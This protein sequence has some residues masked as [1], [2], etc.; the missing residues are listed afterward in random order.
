MCKYATVSDMMPEQRLQF[1]IDNIA[2]NK[3]EQQAYMKAT[4]ADIKLDKTLRV[5]E[6]KG[7]AL[8][9]INRLEERLE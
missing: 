2:N 3:T 1:Y 7:K 8:D 4:E 9:A 6:Y 5:L